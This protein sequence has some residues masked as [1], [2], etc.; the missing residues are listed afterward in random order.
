MTASPLRVRIVLSPDNA[1]WIL[2]KMAQRLA[3]AA[4][5]N[6]VTV[7]VASVPDLSADLNHWMSYAF[8]NERHSTPTTM[9]ITHLDDPYKIAMVARLLKKS[10]DLGICLSSDHARYLA[11]QGVPA[12][13]LAHVVP[14]HDFV[15]SPRPIVIGI[16]TRLYKDGRKREAMLVELARTVDLGAFRFDIFGAGWEPVIERLEAAGARIRYFPGTTDFVADYQA[17]AEALPHFDYYLYLGRDEGSL[18]TLDALAAGV[19]TIVTPQGFHCD[20]PGGITHPVWTQEELN[21]IFHQLAQERRS[22][23][24]AAAPFSWDAYAKAHCRLWSDV[25]HGRPI[26]QPAPTYSHAAAPR[27]ESRRDVALRHFSPFR[28]RSALSHIPILKPVRRWLRRR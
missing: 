19:K 22:L 24:A 14:G 28:I 17:I 26:E 21:Q 6:N 25:V 13:R 5:S 2:E 18:G 7:D 12:E 15:A 1:S 23:A 27:R 9:T 3:D 11:E 16:T 10:V 4:A 8:A 20:L